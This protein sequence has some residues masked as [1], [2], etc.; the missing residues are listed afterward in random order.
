MLTREGVERFLTEMGRGALEARVVPS[1]DALESNHAAGEPLALGDTV[2][3][4]LPSLEFQGLT[5]LAQMLVS[6]KAPEKVKPYI[7]NSPVFEK[8]GA[9]LDVAY[10]FLRGGLTF[11][12]KITEWTSNNDSLTYVDE[13]I[14]LPK[15]LKSWRHTHKISENGDGGIIVD[16][17]EV[18]VDPAMAAP[19]IEGALR[20]HLESRAKA[21]KKALTS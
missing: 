11:T 13:G 3:V 17:L 19:V 9:S 1:T 15:V 2:T 6:A 8:V 16:E 5:G 18:E 7:E 12:S 14:E 10:G 4:S 21:Y 20:L